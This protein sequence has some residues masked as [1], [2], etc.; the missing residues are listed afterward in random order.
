M[1][2]LPD[3]AGKIRRFSDRNYG[4]E[5]VHGYALPKPTDEKW[6][7]PA[8]N[9][10]A[11]T[12][13]DQCALRSSVDDMEDLP[14]KVERHYTL[15]EAIEHFFPGGYITVASL[16]TE[17]RKGRL[18]ATEVAGKF[19]VSESAIAEMLERCR[20]LPSSPILPANERRVA[21]SSGLSET[22]RIARAQAAASALMTS[23][24]SAS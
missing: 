24:R 4:I 1:D 2:D 11:N 3:L 8:G 17:I 22:E 12:I 16:R 21:S 23:K 14:S 9:F 7:V 5:L 15:Q 13:G 19:L 10:P 18:R 6:F 20:V